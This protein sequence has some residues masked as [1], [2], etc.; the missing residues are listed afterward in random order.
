MTAKAKKRA[1]T[2][3]EKPRRRGAPLQSLPSKSVHAAWEY[4]QG[5][6]ETGLESAA[7]FDGAPEDTP[8]LQACVDWLGA[9][10]IRRRKAGFRVPKGSP[11]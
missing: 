9:E 10:L 8:A 2:A 1:R 6:V 5:E 11:R 3:P 7:M 4:L